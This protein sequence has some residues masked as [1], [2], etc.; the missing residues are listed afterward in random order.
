[1]NTPRLQFVWPPLTPGLK[2]LLITFSVI[3]VIH[4]MFSGTLEI[5]EFIVQTLYLSNEGLL[6]H[7]QLWQPLTTLVLHDDFFHAL[8]N[9]LVLYFF[10]GEL[11]KRWKTLKFLVIF[12]ICGLGSD[13]AIVVWHLI[14][15]GELGPEGWSLVRTVG[16]SGAISGVMAA[17]VLY[18]W[19]VP[20]R[21]FLAVSIKGKWLL[22]I[23]LGF[24][25]VGAL[26]GSPVSLPGHLGGMATGLLITIVV[27]KPNNWIGRL[28]LWRLRRKLSVM[29]GGG[30]SL[31]DDPDKKKRNGRTLH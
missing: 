11:E 8:F 4:P 27:F 2:A 15:P 28:K 30:P 17:F 9:G 19:D 20:L 13:L 1:M 6:G 10:G 22:P 23:F 25:I 14:A 29:R 12:L 5:R 18:H 26:F 7:L 16:A 24:D 31:N 21:L 3:Y